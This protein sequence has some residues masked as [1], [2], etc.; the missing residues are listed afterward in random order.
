MNVIFYENLE[1]F[2]TKLA[3]KALFVEGEEYE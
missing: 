3:F 2:G 1:H